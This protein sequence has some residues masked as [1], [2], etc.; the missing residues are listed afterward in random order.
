MISLKDQESLL[1][2][3]STKLTKKITACAIGGNAMIYWGLK[4]STVDV[5][6]VFKSIAD[7]YE[8]SQ[9]LKTSGFERMD[10]AI[11]YGTKQNQPIIFKRT[12]EERFDLFLKDIIHFTFSESMEKRCEKTFE[13][14]DK[15]ILKVANYHDIIIM[16][17]A[18]GREKDREDIRNII[19][20]MEINW[21]IIIE[22]AR[23]QVNLD[24]WN[25]VFS[26]YD[27]LKDMKE[28]MKVD[29]P[30]KVLN[31]L[32]DILNPEKYWKR[33]IKK[34]GRSVRVFRKSKEII[35]K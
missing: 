11:V 32:W 20:N 4:D 24:K 30:Q 6:I 18:T 10:S 23:Y 31:S 17:S 35:H 2:S 28:N 9:A 7:R 22:E 19:G 16:K 26:L 8:F 1:L 5:D 29:I 21:D 27:C 25:S 3:L 13:F 34:L 14:G 33:K 12:A 15:L